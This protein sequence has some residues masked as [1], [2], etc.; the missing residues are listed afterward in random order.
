MTA[1][2]CLWLILTDFTSAP[3]PLPLWYLQSDV[4][5]KFG[6]L[7]IIIIV[8][9]FSRMPGREPIGGL[10]SFG[11]GGEGGGGGG[12]LAVST[13]FSTFQK[14]PLCTTGWCALV[15]AAVK[16][17]LINGLNP[18]SGLSGSR[19]ACGGI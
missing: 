9:M 5:G 3:Q 6:R 7:S 2:T 13:D 14:G 8:N 12:R 18:C 15:Y 4:C 10:G 1:V 19:S 11:R 16:R 17:M